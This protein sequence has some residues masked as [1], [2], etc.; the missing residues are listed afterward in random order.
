MNRKWD[1]S[2]IFLGISQLKI[3]SSESQLQDTV[4]E[5]ELI[6][7]TWA[8]TKCLSGLQHFWVITDHDPLGHYLDEIDNPQLH[9]LHIRL[10]AYNFMVM[11]CKGSTNTTPD[12]LSHYPVSKPNHD[13]VLAEQGEDYSPAPSIYCKAQHIIKW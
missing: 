10:M 2:Y 3:S 11:W 5:L 9:R 8:I 7:I 13:N 12:A 4:I 6:T 1:Q